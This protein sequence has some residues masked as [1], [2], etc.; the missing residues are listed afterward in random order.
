M[1]LA[2]GDDSMMDSSAAGRRV[3]LRPFYPHSSSSA[4][5]VV[6]QAQPDFDSLSLDA[7]E[8]H[9]AMH[10]SSWEGEMEIG[11]MVDVMLEDSQ[12]L[13]SLVQK[14]HFG[15]ADS[16]AKKSRFEPV[17]CTSGEV[18]ACEDGKDCK[19]DRVAEMVDFGMLLFDEFVD[20]QGEGTATSSTLSLLARLRTGREEWDQG[21]PSKALQYPGLGNHASMAAK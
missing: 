19:C 2:H 16:A 20:E 4:S 12:Y 13:D 3:L 21:E 18:D 5:P 14:V 15:A 17:E 9:I 1:S 6:R 8:A 10:R 7:E 11:M